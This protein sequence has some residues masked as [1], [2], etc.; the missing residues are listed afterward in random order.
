MSTT[1]AGEAGEVSQA[2]GEASAIISVGRALSILD[3]FMG[4]DH[5]LPLSELAR[6]VGLPKSTAFRLVAQLTE[7]GFL[8]RVGRNYRLSSHVFELG[9]SVDASPVGFLRDVAA[10]HMAALF[11]HV[12]FGVNLAVLD[13]TSI[14]YL[15]RIRGP[16]S[17]N[18]LSRI[19]ARVPALTTALGKVMLAHSSRELIIQAL[20]EGWPRSTPYTVMRPE[21]MVGQLRQAREAGVAYDREEAMLGLTCVAAPIFDPEGRPVGA[22]SASGS[23]GRFRPESAADLT[24]RAARLISSDLKRTISLRA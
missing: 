17:P 2:R 18:L 11:Q 15:D 14:V 12:G 8:T 20:N 19:G 6:R 24:Q 9:N 4:D 3:A 1:P 13:S 10:P 7:S 5:L 23:T 21:L 16:R 22:I